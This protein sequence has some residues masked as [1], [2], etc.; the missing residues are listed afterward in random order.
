MIRT[1]GTHWKKQWNNK[2]LNLL[3]QI[4]TGKIAI[5]LYLL[6]KKK[7]APNQILYFP[8]SVRLY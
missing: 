2:E 1:S 5:S 6:I 3:M 4:L 8:A 7:N